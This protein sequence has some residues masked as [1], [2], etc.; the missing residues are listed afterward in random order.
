MRTFII[1]QSALIGS[2]IAII[3]LVGTL[4]GVSIILAKKLKK[5]QKLLEAPEV[6]LEQ[7]D[8][9][10]AIAVELE[11]SC[12]SDTVVDL[13]GMETIDAS[14]A[15]INEESKTLT[16]GTQFQTDTNTIATQVYIF[17]LLHIF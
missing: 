14:L 10:E 8:T 12:K 7:H 17:N 9:V 3:V 13:S 2:C 1:N 6:D 11:G 5:V 15:S 4:L 16:V